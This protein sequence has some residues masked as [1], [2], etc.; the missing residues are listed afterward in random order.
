M[1]R[2]AED[3]LPNPAVVLVN[4]DEEVTP[5]AFRAWLD[6]LQSGEPVALEVTA[7]E[8]LAEARAAGEV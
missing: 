4:P 8:T 7:A 6:Q 3:Q 5:E 2:R 1:A